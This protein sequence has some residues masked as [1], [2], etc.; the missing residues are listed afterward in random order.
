MRQKKKIREIVNRWMLP[1]ESSSYMGGLRNV[2]F[3]L[4]PMA[5]LLLIRM[6]RIFRFSIRTNGCCAWPSASAHCQD[7]RKYNEVSST[8][9]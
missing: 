5:L 1:T 3:W 6:E 9:N 4:S 8:R 2:P 7:H